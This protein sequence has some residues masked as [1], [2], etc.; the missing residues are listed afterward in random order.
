MNS[1]F[2]FPLYYLGLLIISLVVIGYVYRS[3][4]SKEGFSFGASKVNERIY[5]K[6]QDKYTDA[7]LFPQTIKN[8][9]IEKQ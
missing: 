7:R 1:E 4:V 6:E 3:I 2:P 8:E 5:L 9:I